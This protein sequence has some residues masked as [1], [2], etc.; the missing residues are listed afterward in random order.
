MSESKQFYLGFQLQKAK[1]R[2]EALV[3]QVMAVDKRYWEL[4][5]I[6]QATLAQAAKAAL[7][8]DQHAKP[9]EQA[10]PGE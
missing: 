2:E 5:H 10:Q 3:T 6:H 1:M 7:E 4:F 8:N 9:F